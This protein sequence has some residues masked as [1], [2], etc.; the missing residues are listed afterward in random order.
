[1]PSVHSLILPPQTR[2]TL[3]RFHPHLPKTTRLSTHLETSEISKAQM[4]VSLRLLLVL[5][6]WQVVRA[7]LTVGRQKA[8]VTLKTAPMIRMI[9]INGLLQRIHSETRSAYLF[10]Y[11]YSCCR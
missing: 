4:T 5:G 7:L 9:E 11:R 3:L 8:P 2:Q 10:R 6:L 1:M